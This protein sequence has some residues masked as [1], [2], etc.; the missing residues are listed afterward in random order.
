MIDS[1]DTHYTTHLYAGSGTAANAATTNG[2]TK[3]TVADNTT[4][5]NS[6]TVKGTGATTV[7]SNASGVI[8]IN[9][10]DTRDFKI[11]KKVSSATNDTL[12][13]IYS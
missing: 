5:R 12:Y 2:N 4:V 7:V 3:L 11:G 8:T 10:S 1:S 9:S 13:F 6:I